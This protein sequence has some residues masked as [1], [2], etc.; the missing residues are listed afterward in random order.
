MQ[1]PENVALR[2]VSVHFG[3]PPRTLEGR[4]VSADREFAKVELL[5]AAPEDL[6]AGT[7]IVV[8][9]EG[10][11][12]LELVGVVSATESTRLEIEMSRAGH[13]EQRWSPRERGRLKF[14]YYRMDEAAGDADGWLDGAPTPDA[15]GVEP[16]PRVELSL[17]GLAFLSPAELSGRLRIAF[18]HRGREHRLLA[19]VVRTDPTRRIGIQKVCVRFVRTPPT[20]GAALADILTALQ[21]AALEGFQGTCTLDLPQPESDVAEASE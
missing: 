20:T 21:D 18:V 15:P 19:Q 12:N 4:L 10:E 17:D 5:G 7:G 3:S 11:R 1:N 8:R 16:D 2:P 14:R 13:R 6:T 9:P